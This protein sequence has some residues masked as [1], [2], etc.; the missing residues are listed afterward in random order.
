L[1]LNYLLGR[2]QVSLMQADAAAC[3]EAR[4]AHRGMAREYAVMISEIQTDS[5]AGAMLAEAE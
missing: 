5:G 3:P 2:H 1:D 4:Y